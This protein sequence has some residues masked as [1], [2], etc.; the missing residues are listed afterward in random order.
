M[1]LKH[2]FKMIFLNK[3]EVVFFFFAHSLMVSLNMKQ[4][5]LAQVQ[6]LFTHS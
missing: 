6:D 2:I 5:N 4:F 1:I 3:S